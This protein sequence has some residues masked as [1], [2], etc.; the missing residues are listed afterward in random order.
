MN[1]LHIYKYNDL[2]LIFLVCKYFNKQK[3]L[4]TFAKFIKVF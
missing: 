2:V 4:H 3:V 1:L